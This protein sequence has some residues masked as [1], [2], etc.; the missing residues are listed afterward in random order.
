MNIKC[1]VPRSFV[2]ATSF[3]KECSDRSFLRLI[4]FRAIIE[5]LRNISYSVGRR[6]GRISFLSRVHLVPSQSVANS[7]Q[8]RQ[9]EPGAF[10]KT[11]YAFSALY[12][13][14]IETLRKLDLALESRCFARCRII[15]KV[16]LI[17]TGVFTE[18]RVFLLWRAQTRSEGRPDTSPWKR[19][20]I[21]RPAMWSRDEIYECFQL[22]TRDL[23]L[24]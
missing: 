16:Q 14:N 21:K 10:N 5:F 24:Q 18:S 6:F 1:N 17:I 23:Y 3:G 20:P 15:H 11:L 22:V 9:R 8:G 13:V 19:W 4:S 2:F 12:C 7:G